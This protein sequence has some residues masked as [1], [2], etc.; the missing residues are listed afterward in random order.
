[1]LNPEQIQEYK[2]VGAIVVPNVLSGHDVRGLPRTRSGA[3]SL[4]TAPGWVALFMSWWEYAISSWRRRSGQDAMLTFLC[5]LGPPPYAATGADGKELSDRWQEALLLKD[6]IRALWDRIESE[7]AGRWPASPFF[8]IN[9]RDPQT[10]R[11]TTSNTR[12]GFCSRAV[13]GRTPVHT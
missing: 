10:P 11:V 9:T 4:P 6:T 2:H 8:P 5:E 3:A 12:V 7:N 13:L 1:M